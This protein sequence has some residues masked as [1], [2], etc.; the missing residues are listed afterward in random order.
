MQFWHPWGRHLQRT[1]S[2]LAPLFKRSSPHSQPLYECENH[3]L[4][5]FAL[6]K[7]LLQWPICQGITEVQII[8]FC[9]I[10]LALILT[11]PI[12]RNMFPE[13]LVQACF[14]QVRGVRGTSIMHC[15][16]TFYPCLKCHSNPHWDLVSIHCVAMWPCERN[17]DV[18]KCDQFHSSTRPSAKSWSLRRFQPTPP[19]FHLSQL[20]SWRW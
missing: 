9:V 16:S 7:E 2:V 18:V 1:I 10:G 15:S 14:Q 6:L 20:L 8:T 4:L 3:S 12:N 5:D 19:Q 11:F 17:S 13:N